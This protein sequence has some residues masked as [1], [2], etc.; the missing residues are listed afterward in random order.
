MRLSFDGL[1]ILVFGNRERFHDEAV[2]VVVAACGV[3]EPA[4]GYKASDCQ[5]ALPDNQLPG[6][7]V[8]PVGVLVEVA[9]HAVYLHRLV[10]VARNHPVVVPFFRQVLVIVVCA[11]VG[12]E[13]RTPDIAFDGV[14]VGRQGEEKLV[15]TLHVRFGFHRA[16]LR[17][18]LRESQHQ[19]LAVIEDINLLPLF[20]GEAV[21]VPHGKARYQC[22]QA[23]EYQR[24]EPDLPEARFD[25]VQ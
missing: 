13:Q 21:R 14:L 24:K 9:L 19:A 15:E 11:L 8:H 10:D 20:L 25:V 16:V 18:V 22:A 5:A 12:E 17:H 6:I 2:R 3:Q 7:G 4:R 1:Q 23:D